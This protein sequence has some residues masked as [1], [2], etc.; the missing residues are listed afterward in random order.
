MDSRNLNKEQ[1]YWLN[2]QLGAM[3]HRLCLIHQ[4]MTERKFPQDDKLYSLVS[5]AYHAVLTA[6]HHA[7]ALCCQG[8]M[9]TTQFFIG[10]D[11]TGGEQTLTLGVATGPTQG[12]P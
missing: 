12:K 9:G 2:D 8:Q 11:G 1:C 5:N 4:R 3:A 7:Q 10:D 6:D